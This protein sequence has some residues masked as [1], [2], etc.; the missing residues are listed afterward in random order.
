MRAVLFSLV[1]SLSVSIA[2]AQSSAEKFAGIIQTPE[3][4]K[5]FDGL[6]EKLGI[7][8]EGTGEKVLITHLGDNLKVTEGFDSSEVD[9]ILP[10]QPFNVSDMVDHSKDGKIDDIEATRIARV[11]FTPFTRVTLMDPVFAANRKRKAAGIEDLIHVYLMFPEDSVAD[12]HTLIYAAE[13]WVVIDGIVGNPDRVFK[14]TQGPALEYQR[15]IFKAMQTDTRKGWIS[16]VK[17][18]KKWR[19]DYSVAY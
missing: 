3:I 7:V 17:W 13:Q 5:F 4:A 14:L 15:Q 10:L 1:L 2:S 9:F 8:V 6:F 19:K 12:S 18:Y 16:F 11:F